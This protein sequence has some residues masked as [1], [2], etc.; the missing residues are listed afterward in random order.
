MTRT[1][2]EGMEGIEE[3]GSDGKRRE[4][5]VGK[6]LP[7]KSKRRERMGNIRRDGQEFEGMSHEREW[8]R[9][10]LERMEGTGRDD[11]GRKGWKGMVADGK[12]WTGMMKG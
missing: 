2:R 11:K 3:T 8:E 12:I 9:K 4:V 5:P 6:I 1:E 7:T 10:E